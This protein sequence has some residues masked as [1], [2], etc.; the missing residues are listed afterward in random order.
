MHSNFKTTLNFKIDQYLFKV[1]FL[2]VTYAIKITI[3]H[4]M[5]P[6]LGIIL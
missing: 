3:L 1:A 5:S 2:V 6:E 4:S